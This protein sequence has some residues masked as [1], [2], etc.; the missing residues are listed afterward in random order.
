MYINV[1][2]FL[3]IL[4]MLALL[5]GGTAFAVEATD[6]PGTPTQDVVLSLTAN[7]LDEENTPYD[8]EVMEPDQLAMDTVTEIYK[9]VFEQDN[10][11]VR[12]FPEETQRQIEE[13]LE[14]IVDP[15]ALYM[16]EFM[17]LHAAE[18]E[19]E[20]D[21][22]AE[23]LVDVDYQ[24]DQLILVV[25]GD[26][27][28]SEN[29]VWTPVESRVVELGKVEFT[30]PQAL[31]EE[32]QGE[33]VLFSLLTVRK[34]AR[35]G[36]ISE[37]YWETEH[38]QLPSKTAKDSVKLAKLVS[39]DG[40]QIEDDFE[41]LIVEESE[42]IIRELALIREHVKEE[43]QPVC[44]WLPDEERDEIQLL[45]SDG[46]DRDE[47]VVYDYL[48]LITKNY[49]DTYGDVIST[50]T[51][52]TPY[53]E[54]QQVV[55]VLGLPR[56]TPVEGET[57][58]DW[59]AQRAQVNENGEVEIVFDQLALIGMGEETGLLLVLCEPIAE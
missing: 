42:I 35:G 47:L 20:T 40:T 19:P 9:F 12:Y 2:R 59:A 41:L 51:F 39:A 13:M 25:L 11:P 3:G 52:A 5:L 36:V 58:M 55:T 1:K 16:T 10:R 33:D 24:S 27:S 49:K 23:M 57:L 21:L 31:M 37:E 17:R 32:L 30:V 28:D 53:E 38:I 45:L 7:W 44:T 4:L 26:T 6:A 43:E 14:G 54:D 48:P 50:F 15:D 34:G 56:E 22:L 18:A 29:L 46:L 8:L